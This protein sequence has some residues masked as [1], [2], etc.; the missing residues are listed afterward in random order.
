MR[1]DIQGS[2]VLFIARAPQHLGSV[3]AYLTTRKVK[4]W[5]ATSFKDAIEKI[6]TP[7]RFGCNSAA[8]PHSASLTSRKSN[9]VNS[10]SRDR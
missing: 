8:G 4:T 3:L 9:A 5:T 1:K 7:V 2:R 10:P 6:S